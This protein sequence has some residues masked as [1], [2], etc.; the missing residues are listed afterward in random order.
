MA[1][2]N[3]LTVNSEDTLTVIAGDWWVLH[4][5]TVYGTVVGR[6]NIWIIRDIEPIDAFSILPRVF[7]DW[8]TVAAVGFEVPAALRRG[9]EP[10]LNQRK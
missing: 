7:G 8:F 2:K 3:I 5:L 9:G 1:F 10:P 4:G 6:E